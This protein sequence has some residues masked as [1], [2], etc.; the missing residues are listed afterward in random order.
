[1]MIGTIHKLFTAKKQNADN[2]VQIFNSSLLNFNR[3]QQNRSTTYPTTY[4]N[5]ELKTPGGQPIAE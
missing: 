2:A 1:M 3:K 5:R 4:C